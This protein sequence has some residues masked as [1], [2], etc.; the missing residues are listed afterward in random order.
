MSS[1][2]LSSASADVI[3]ANKSAADAAFD[4]AVEERFLEVATE[5]GVVEDG[6]VDRKLVVG[7]VYDEL[8]TKHVSSIDPES[9]DRRDPAKSSHKEELAEAIFTSMPTGSEADGNR[10][11]A[12]VRERCLAAVWNV[13]QTGERGQVQKRLRVDNLVLVRGVVFRGSATLTDG[14][15][16]STHEEVVLR[17]FL[18][19]RLEKLRKLTEAIEGDFEMVAARAPQLRAPMRAAIEAAV[20][21]A[22][23][24][25]PVETLGSGQR[26]DQ[27]A[28][29]R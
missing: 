11:E 17:E 23:A 1:E 8:K 14:L 19:P 13:T 5:A 12:K 21:E 28:L 4:R 15:F 20:I 27:K 18:G 29:D 22:T 24:K 6:K 16:V 26:S 2:V 3:A 7:L 10:V 25:L 9:D